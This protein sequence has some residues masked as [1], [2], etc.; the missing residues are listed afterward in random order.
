MVEI[1]SVIFLS[2]VNVNNSIYLLVKKYIK[3]SHKPSATHKDFGINKPLT[4][5]ENE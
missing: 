1:K 5:I 3:T 2:A 4:G